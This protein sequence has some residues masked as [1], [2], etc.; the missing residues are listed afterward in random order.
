MLVRGSGRGWAGSLVVFFLLAGAGCASDPPNPKVVAEDRDEDRA[1]RQLAK[2]R[3]TNDEAR[4]RLLIERFPDTEAAGDARQELATIVAVQ[5]EEAFK[6]GDPQTAEAKAVEAKIHGD[7]A[8][9]RKVQTILDQ[10]DDQ[11]SEKLADETA[12]LAV[13][14]RC[15]SALK[16]VGTVMRKKPRQRFR[17]AVQK[18]TQTQLIECLGKKMDAAIAEGNVDQARMMLESKDATSSFSNEGYKLANLRLQKA[19]VRQSMG[20]IDP[21]LNARKWADAIGKIDALKAKGTFNP[22]E[23]DVAFSIIQDA[24]HGVLKTMVDKSMTSKTPIADWA[25][26]EKEAAFAQ[27]KALPDDIVA[28]KKMLDVN[29][30]CEK[31]GCKYQAPAKAWAWGEIP[32]HPRRDAEGSKS[33]DIAHADAIWVT[34]KSKTKWLVSKEKPEKTKGAEL[35]QSVD[36]WAPA[37]NFKK[38]DTETWLPPREQMV[39]VRIWGPLWDQKEKKDEYILGTVT[40]VDGTTLTVKRLTDSKETDVDWK[41]IFLGNFPKG[42]RVFAFCIDELHPEEA[43]ILKVVS[44]KGANPRVKVDCTKGKKT[45]VE[46]G[47]GLS[48]R[49]A[50]LPKRKP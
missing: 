36:G 4:Y 27:W 32:V 19:I 31:L 2:A 8:T 13:Q 38:V 17:D 39:G 40:K 22:K 10:I 33:G 45:R 5:A 26:I 43:K 34:A 3:E 41:D 37:E 30:Q 42:M 46:V 9:T 24:I 44:L 48:T 50:W 29:I 47:S 35:Y 11:R 49:K 18:K 21:L 1:A 23:R 20:E 25:A 28:A 15:A 16:A 12:D 6:S 14:G 7:L